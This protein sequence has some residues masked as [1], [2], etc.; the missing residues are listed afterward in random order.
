MI[1]ALEAATATIDLHSSQL[2]LS[3]FSLVLTRNDYFRAILL[4][5]HI[6]YYAHRDNGEFLR[7]LLVLRSCCLDTI[8]GRLAKQVFDECQ[9]KALSLQE[10]RAM[11]P[12][13]GMEYFWYVSAAIGLVS[14]EFQTAKSE[15]LQRQ[16]SDRVA[17]LL[18]KVLAL[19]DDPSE[20]TLATEV[21]LNLSLQF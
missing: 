17:K 14:I 5:C 20:E 10:E 8:L 12:G 16:A 11:R 3:N 13:R 2:K 19:Q 15:I 9:E 21:G 7:Y 6:A 18:Y 1:T 4:I